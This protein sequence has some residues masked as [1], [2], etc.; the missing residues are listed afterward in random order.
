MFLQGLS[1]MHNSHILHRDLKPSNLLIRSN[2]QLVIADFGLAR[3]YGSAVPMTTEV[4]T[5]WYRP[6]ELLFGASFYSI[7]VD[8]WAAGCI[9]A[10]MFLREPLLPGMFSPS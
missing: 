7:G 4:V 6:P 3:N 8:M 2:G 1:H 5:R 10:E 9:F